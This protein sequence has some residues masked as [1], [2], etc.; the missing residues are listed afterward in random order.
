MPYSINLKSYTILLNQQT[1]L[2][3]DLFKKACDE[4]IKPDADN[5]LSTDL[6]LSDKQLRKGFFPKLL[7]K[8][9]NFNE[10]RYGANFITLNAIDHIRLDPNADKL[11]DAYTLEINQLFQE[12]KLKPYDLSQID[13]IESAALVFRILILRLV[14]IALCEDNTFARDGEI[15]LKIYSRFIDEVLCHI[16]VFAE[17]QRIFTYFSSKEHVAWM[18]AIKRVISSVKL[19]HS[20]QDSLTACLTT[21]KSISLSIE[22]M[23]LANL[24]IAH[25]ACQWPIR[26]ILFKKLKKPQITLADLEDDFIDHKLKEYESF[27][28]KKNIFKEMPKLN[29]LIKKIEI[30]PFAA[31]EHLDRQKNILSI[32]DVVDIAQVPQI[33][34]LIS[35]VNNQCPL[36]LFEKLTELYYLY[37]KS[38]C[39]L[40]SLEQIDELITACSWVPLVMGVLDLTPLCTSIQVYCEK[41]SASLAVSNT[42]QINSLSFKQMILQKS[43]HAQSQLKDM[44]GQVKSLSELQDTTKIEKIKYHIAHN[45][46]NIQQVQSA[47]EVSLLHQK[48]TRP[49]NTSLIDHYRLF[50]NRAAIGSSIEDGHYI[51]KENPYPKLKT[52]RAIS[53][54]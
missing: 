50:A 10:K 25:S 53:Y 34:A 28:A 17:E 51:E 7:N 18:D 12:N 45:M 48:I 47:L 16:E 27:L 22:R 46:S 30:M 11:L 4:Y 26:S 20:H 23:I 54:L 49:S 44:L 37:F 32:L 40:I 6:V 2:I 29:E 33:A 52:S 31:I 43:F 14:T 35:L 39:L 38:R 24:V 42:D 13:N 5:K 9:E 1:Q 19:I 41:A 36:D 3:L 15:L 8:I 21:L